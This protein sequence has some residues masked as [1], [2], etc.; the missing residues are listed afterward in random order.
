MINIKKI[1][2]NKLIS[3]VFDP[4]VGQLA[5]LGADHHLSGPAMFCFN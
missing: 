1:N 2:K 5:V 3:A 4:D